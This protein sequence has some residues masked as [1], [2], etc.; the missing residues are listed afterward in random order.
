MKNKQRNSIRSKTRRGIILFALI[1]I[2]AVSAPVCYGCMVMQNRSF[3]EEIQ[4]HARSARSIPDGDR[5]PLYL[6]TGTEDEDYRQTL[7][8]LMTI[9]SAYGLSSLIVVAP[10]GD[11]WAVVWD[12]E[13]ASDAYRL[14]D[15]IDLGNGEETALRAMRGNDLNTQLW[16]HSPQGRDWLWAFSA[17]LDSRGQPVAAACVEHIGPDTGETILQF[18]VVI[19]LVTAVVSA[20]MM[21]VTYVLLKK[22]I[23][24][25]VRALTDAAS[26]MVGSL[27]SE[28]TVAIDVHTN[29]ELETLA[30]AFTAMDGDLRDYVKRL[31]VVTAEKER[32]G[33]ELDLAARIQRGLLPKLCPPF[34]ENSEFELAASMDA[35]KEVGGDF[36]DFFM[37]DDRHIALAM[38]DVSGKGVPAALF[39]VVTKVL[40]K[41]AVKTG[42]SPSE[43]LRQVNELL[44]DG[45]DPGMFVTV[46]L[47]VID[48]D[49][50]K[51]VAVNAGHEHPALCRSGG[52]ELVKYRHSMAVATMEGLRFPQHEFELATGDTLFVYT[53]GVTEA[54]DADN[55]LFGNDR[56]LEAMNLHRDAAPAEL[57]SAV[58][59]AIDAFTGN[60]PQFDDITML[61]FRYNGRP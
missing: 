58:R 21:A 20:V 48:L 38:A 30:D 13:T 15:K 35:A 43:A 24:Q 56:L 7:R 23:I 32:I 10:D 41:N 22:Q 16:M 6:E 55:R 31:A 39:M 27:E 42:A 8:S 4:A 11:G 12:T 51:G 5:I 46:W 2:V 40:I 26:R 59:G 54:T 25:P 17:V 37:V 61:A 44:L 28:E 19:V 14:G 18:L 34:T 47:A 53:D 57:L 52:F 36:Y 50:G 45:N 1:M 9:R 29:D 33:A 60:A 3:V 49:T